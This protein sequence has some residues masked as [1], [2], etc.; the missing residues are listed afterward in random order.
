[1]SERMS[2]NLSRLSVAFVV[3]ALLA[4]A[5][6]GDDGDVASS[7]V[8]SS[9]GAVFGP[10]DEFD[11]RSVAQPD[12]PR[13]G[14]P[15]VL[16]PMSAFE[17]FP[18]S[19]FTT[20]LPANPV[21]SEN[22]ESYVALLAK[23]VKDDGSSLALRTFTNPVY[24][25]D[26]STPR[27]DVTLSADWAPA[28][29]IF[30]VPIP[31]GALADPED[32]GN[33]VIIDQARR[34]E[35][36]MWQVHRVGDQWSA[37][38]ANAISLD[39]NGVFPTGLSSRGS[40]FAL[41][42]GMIWPEE[43]QRG[44]IDHAIIF[45]YPFT[46]AAGSVGD[47]TESDGWSDRPDALPEGAR[48]R[49]DPTLNI[50]TLGLSEWQATI[51]RA[52]QEYGLVLVD[53]GGGVQFYGIHSWSAITDPWTGVI[54]SQAE[55]IS[56]DDIPFDRLEVLDFGTPVEREVTFRPDPCARFDVAGE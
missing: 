42:Q 22:S 38:W 53:D 41:I 50:D 39:G 3:L 26:E 4:T 10:V 35:W 46:S 24:L 32:D 20:P 9:D 11:A 40:G 44:R 14:V 33:I 15:Q 47:S 7:D 17:I 51:A 36:D 52:M 54:D 16:P 2:R 19:S 1:M 34:C 5:C 27:R 23:V 31:D 29:I 30:D 37:S 45:S 48:L 13:P 8:V 12:G 55:Y 49:L 25:V 21:I 6:G 28:G 18:E 56:L 43:I